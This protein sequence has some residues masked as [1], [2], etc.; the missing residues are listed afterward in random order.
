MSALNTFLSNYY[1]DR[2]IESKRDLAE[3]A[4]WQIPNSLKYFYSFA[5]KYP[6]IVDPQSGLF[7]NNGKNVHHDELFIGELLSRKTFT[8]IHTNIEEDNPPVWISQTTKGGSQYVEEL[9]CHSL[10]QFI[11]TFCLERSL[12]GTAHFYNSEKING[13]INLNLLSAIAQQDYQVDL[14]WETINFWD[15]VHHKTPRMN[16]YYSVEDAI[17]ICSN[18]CCATNHQNANRLL[19]SILA[20]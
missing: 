1:G 14:L 12:L 11:T 20:L 3:I 13:G 5:E 2:Q 15:I 8:V 17:L 19:K 16:Y 4:A 18:G 9:V 10:S 6:T 7:V